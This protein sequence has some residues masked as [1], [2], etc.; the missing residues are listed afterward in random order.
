MQI[1]SSIPHLFRAPDILF[2]TF[3]SVPS[4]LHAPV[5]KWHWEL[6]TW[7]AGGLW[8]GDAPPSV[9][10]SWFVDCWRPVRTFVDVSWGSSCTRARQL[11]SISRKRRGSASKQ[12]PA[13]RPTSP[14]R[15]L[16]CLY[17]TLSCWAAVVRGR[18][19]EPEQGQEDQWATGHRWLT[20]EVELGQAEYCQNWQ[21]FPIRELRRPLTSR[22]QDSSFRMF[23]T[24]ILMLGWG[25]L[26]NLSWWFISQPVIGF[27][28][29]VFFPPNHTFLYLEILTCYPRT[30]MGKE[31]FLFLSLPFSLRLLGEIPCSL[32]LLGQMEVGKHCLV[33]VWWLLI[34]AIDDV[35]QQADFHH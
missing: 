3:F 33:A 25:Q 28:F 16:P 18:E 13:C 10:G 21:Q 5:F 4:P 24:V 34:S 32:G 15:P 26:Q 19:E 20:W 6:T 17:H 27:G 22:I 23:D 12:A 1:A 7:M 31:I 14:H 30:G 8:W 35:Q 9:S 29:F 2:L 11:S